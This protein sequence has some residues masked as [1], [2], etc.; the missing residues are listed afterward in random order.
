[1]EREVRGGGSEGFL[2]CLHSVRHGR[3]TFPDLIINFL[4][5]QLEIT[6]RHNGP[7]KMKRH[8]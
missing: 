5:G 6:K 8:L 4:S 7:T 3:P 2:L 1:M